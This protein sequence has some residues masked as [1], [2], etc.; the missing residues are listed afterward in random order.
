LKEEREAAAFPALKEDTSAKEKSA[1]KQP[2]PEKAV[3]AEKTS[4]DVEKNI[5]EAKGE[6]SAEIT[7]SKN[8]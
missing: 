8:Q 6:S 5:Q 3:E 1:D 4:G 2:E 7:D